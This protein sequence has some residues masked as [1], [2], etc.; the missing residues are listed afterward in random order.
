MGSKVFWNVS[1]VIVLIIIIAGLG[2]LYLDYTAIQK[3]NELY[4]KNKHLRNVNAEYGLLISNDIDNLNALNRK[5]QSK[6]NNNEVFVSYVNE[7]L[8]LACKSARE[9]SICKG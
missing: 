7:Y 4:E 6:M 8:P 9:K 5:Y 1:L 3:Q 2:F